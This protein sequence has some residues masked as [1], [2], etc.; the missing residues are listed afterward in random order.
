VES[1][2]RAKILATSLA[3]LALDQN[4]EHMWTDS[5]PSCI[6]EILMAEKQF[7]E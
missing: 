1:S 6:H 7:F 5:F 3:K 2:T 4:V